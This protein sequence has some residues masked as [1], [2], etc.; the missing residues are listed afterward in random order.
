[1]QQVQQYPGQEKEIYEF[2]QKN[3]DAIGGLRAPIFEEKVVDHILEQVTVEDKTVTKDEL[4]KEDEL[5]L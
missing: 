4:M 1:M 5:P 3:P 2:F